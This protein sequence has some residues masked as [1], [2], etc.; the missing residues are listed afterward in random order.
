V[1]GQTISHYRITEK[2][3][4]GGMGV[5][6][7]AEDTELGRFVAL[8]FLPPEMAQDAQATERFRREARAASALNHAN[9]CTIYEIGEHEKRPFIAMEYLEG[10]T[11][12]HRIAG[13]P[14]D[15]ETVLDI[16]IQVADA[17][18]AAHAKGIVHRDI[19]PANIFVT[20]RGVAKI[21]D[22]GLAKMSLQEAG[23]ADSA[24]T[25]MDET[26][27][28]HL[29]SPGTA[30]GTVAYMS[31]EQVRGQ[32][33]D[34]RTDLFSFGAVLYEMC[35]GAIPFRGETSGVIFHSILELPPVAPVRVNPGVPP[36]LE[37]IIEK[38][39]EKNRDLRYHNAADMRADLKRL[40]RDTDSSRHSTSVG[41]AAMPP[42]QTKRTPWAAIS[43][44]AAV[45]IL[46]AGAAVFLAPRWLRPAS[47]P[48]TRGSLKVRELT[49][50]SPENRALVAE[51]SS[52]GKYLAYAD[53]RGLRLLT[54][55]T[56]EVH[57]VELP[58]ALRRNLWAPSWFPDDETLLLMAQGQTGKFEIWSASIFGGT[59]HKL[60]DQAYFG[61]VSPDGKRIAFVAE[62]RS[63][64]WLTGPDGGAR[65]ALLTAETGTFEDIAWSPLGDRLAYLR[66]T[67]E[68]SLETIA[69]DGSQP[70]VVLQDDRIAVSS[71]FGGNIFW[72]PDGRLLFIRAEAD[73]SSQVLYSLPVDPRTGRASDVKP[74]RV[75]AWDDGS[76]MT[77][78]GATKDGKRLIV[79]KMKNRNNVYVSELR[80]KAKKLDP[81][82]ALSATDAQSFP[83]GWTR[84]SQSV[85]YRSAVAGNY[86]IYRQRVGADSAES[87]AQGSGFLDAA[88]ST[89]DA[90]WIL[91]LDW[92]GSG[93]NSTVSLMRLPAS[94]GSA[95]EVFTISS[96]DA[97]LGPLCPTGQGGVC[98]F[99]R[100]PSRKGD[101]SFFEV[102]PVHG[103]GPK[104]AESRFKAE[105][106][107]LT[108]SVSPDGSHLVLASVKQ[109]PREFL[110]LD[111]RRNTE[112]KVAYP[113][114]VRLVWDVEWAPD[115]KALLATVLTTSFEIL[116]IGLDGRADALLDTGRDQWMDVLAPS[117]DGHRLAFNKQIFEANAWLLEN[118]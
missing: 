55:D 44:V 82:V 10:Q 42:A 70:T 92:R 6:Y 26:P 38:A 102:D 36:K 31:P 59:A 40:K 84:D 81:P 77:V 25:V 64:V 23:P 49:F 100:S 9:I 34:A 115:G 72:T 85:L 89:P 1:I 78:G 75:F 30:V 58:D 41:M 97:V 86:H 24:E 62:D 61:R 28:S 66:S 13:K 17:L 98:L 12:K 63:A 5:V 106:D 15:L 118:F 111:L 4:G 46:L 110:I 99:G 57:D 73:S 19:K 47:S 53:T 48:V 93:T 33:L 104:V 95:E 27:P 2:I 54:I 56:G 18:D 108:A 74:R 43:A 52:D 51:M 87:I 101:W 117:P 7:K 94:G 8:K 37:E 91:Y 39:L 11:L 3:G 35:T 22:F 69:V 20:T 16:G 79:E 116:H 29:T 68:T 96:Q 112:T 45:V 113:E 67:P 88:T 105:P 109:L 65:R 50:T 14:L 90:A 114:R 60:T 80:D 71:E 76:F 107:D 83:T 103:L 21:L 32:N